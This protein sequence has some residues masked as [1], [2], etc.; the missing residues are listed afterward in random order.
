MSYLLFF[1]LNHPPLFSPDGGRLGQRWSVHQQGWQAVH[2][3]DARTVLCRRRLMDFM[4]QCDPANDWICV[5][6]TFGFLVILWLDQKRN[7]RFHRPADFW[8]FGHIVSYQSNTINSNLGDL[9]IID[10]RIVFWFI[11]LLRPK[12]RVANAS[13]P[14]PPVG[15]PRPC[16]RTGTVRAR[17]WSSF[18]EALDNKLWGEKYLPKLIDLSSW[19]LT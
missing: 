13:R 6:F 3:R 11:S 4:T 19:K 16:H 2:G 18:S 5:A 1:C 7:T 14:G 8:P 12:P 9:Q 10:L 15:P 17:S